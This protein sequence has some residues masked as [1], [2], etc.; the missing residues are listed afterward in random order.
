MFVAQL[1]A[2][3]A[4][5]AEKEPWEVTGT[6]AA[7]GAKVPASGLLLMKWLEGRIL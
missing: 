1:T 7:L 6:A 2:A 5:R 4:A 3:L